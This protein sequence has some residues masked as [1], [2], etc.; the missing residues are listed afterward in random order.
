VIETPWAYYLF[1]LDSLQAAGVAPMNQVQDEVRAAAAA[2]KRRELVRTLAEQ[3][4]ADIAAGASLE[5]VAERH[6][7]PVRTL[8]PFTRYTPPTAIQNAPAVVGAAFRFGVGET[9]GPVHTDAGS[10]FVRTERKMLADSITFAASIEQ[11]RTA[12]IQQARQERA[13][14]ILTSLREAATVEDR[15]KDLARAQRQASESPLFPV[16]F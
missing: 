1:R 11:L 5:T 3:V 13:Q 7:L 16:G 2:Q 15:R 14:L 6:D 8:G 12:A 4:A 10:Y 9:G